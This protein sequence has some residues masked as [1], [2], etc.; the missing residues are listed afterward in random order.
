MCDEGRLRMPELEDDL[1]DL[2]ELPY[3]VKAITQEEAE[4]RPELRAD[5]SKA[6]EGVRDPEDPAELEDLELE[7]AE[8]AIL[9]E[10]EGEGAA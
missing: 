7:A 2:V 3:E 5:P 8:A 6:P 1:D 10:E 4:A 9:G